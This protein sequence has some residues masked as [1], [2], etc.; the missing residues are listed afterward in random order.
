MLFS[1]VAMDSIVNPIAA[2]AF[3]SGEKTELQNTLWRGL[4]IVLGV[5]VSLLIVYCLLSK[6]LIIHVFGVDYVKAVTPLLVLSVGYLGMSFFGRGG[7]ILSM[8][9]NEKITA[10]L[11]AGSGILNIILNWILIP[12][13]GIDGAAIATAVSVTV[14]IIMEAYLAYS[15]TGINTTI[16][17]MNKL[18]RRRN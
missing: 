14:R 8:S 6:E 9:H 18:V 10:T 13:Y 11:I 12:V 4:W 16:F 1:I 17:N 2:K 7:V 15:L 3:A 5:S